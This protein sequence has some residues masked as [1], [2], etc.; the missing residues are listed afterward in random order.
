MT[1][2]L[3]MWLLAFLPVLVVLVAMLVLH[4]NSKLAGAAAL[5]TAVLVA[6][7]AFGA[8]LPLVA[9]AVGKSL[10]LSADVLFIIW[11]ALLLY[12]VANEA[13]A[14]TVL[15][16]A[17]TRLTPDRMLQGLFLGWVF[18]SFLQGM[19]GFGVPVAVAAPLLVQLGFSPISAV[20]MAC[21]GHGWAVNFGSLATSFTTLLAVTGLSGEALAPMSAL[22]L[23]IAGYF[24]G[25]AVAYL[26]G[27]SRGLLRS[28]PAVVVL[29]T[30][31]GWTQYALAANGLWTLGS[32][33]GGMAGLAVALILPKL[34]LYR[35][36]NRSG[37]GGMPAN[38]GAVI[39]QK[40]REL[41]LG[42]AMAAYLILVVLTFAL[43]LIPGLSEFLG[44][45]QVNFWFPETRTALGWVTAAG[46]GRGVEIF[47]HPGAILVYSCA[48]AF[49]LYWRRGMYKPGAAG[50]IWAKTVRGAMGSTW[51]IL[52]MVA[53]SVV[54]THSGM[55]T[56]LAQGLGA[57]FGSVYP[58][59]S[60][61]IGAL[62]GFITGSNNSSSVLFGAL[63]RDAARLLGLS[64][65]LILGGQAA[66]GSIG[67]I[68]APAKVLVGSAAVGLSR[69]EGRVMGR[70]MVFAL[71]IIGLL[72]LV[73]WAF[74]ALGWG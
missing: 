37:E 22:L 40:E 18:A 28:I 26:A 66:G 62:G 25:L 55:T 52:A 57:A 74:S 19:G 60:P 3:G 5:V 23:W 9:V 11:G 72:A 54:M 69:E 70:V 53:M 6:L 24:C 27:G 58:L 71:P 34:P 73:V 41:P 36:R 61:L 33:G 59:A 50:R 56:L 49:W 45:V 7:L 39:P 38:P 31:M 8:N 20:I 43:N 1:L 46:P 47:G 44:R 4:W 15:G 12:H 68:M 67:S 42:L 29:G 16:T 17:L 48:L 63:Q 30:V 32:T 10:L 65:P 2:N 51:G 35:S 64:V 13:G 21:V 14:V